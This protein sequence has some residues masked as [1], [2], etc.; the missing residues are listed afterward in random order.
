MV[1]DGVVNI[2][3]YTTGSLTS[4]LADTDKITKNFTASCV[5]AGFACPLN[6]WAPGDAVLLLRKLE[7]F[8][9][10]LKTAPIAGIVSGVPVVVG[11]SNVI[12]GMFSLWESPLTGFPA[13]ATSLYELGLG[14]VTSFAVPDSSTPTTAPPAYDIAA[15][16]VHIEC[17]DSTSRANGTLAD[18][19]PILRK[20]Q[21][22]SPHFGPYVAFSNLIP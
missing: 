10:S 7:A 6:E 14:N 21:K 11:Y 17:T 1:L 5:L 9:E 4:T 16:L 12:A 19:L 20:M 15:T 2:S 3:D 18:F 13:V 22:L 8:L